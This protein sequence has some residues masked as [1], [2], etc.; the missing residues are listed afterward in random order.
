M[1][2]LSLKFF[3]GTAMPI[4]V[5]LYASYLYFVP[6][7]LDPVIWESPCKLFPLEENTIL[8]HGIKLHENAI[9]A[10]ESFAFDEHTGL[11]YSGLADGRVMQFSQMGE[12]MGTVLF[13]GGYISAY[14]K[15]TQ[16]SEIDLSSYTGMEESELF[17]SCQALL[18]AGKLSSD[19]SA[20][21]KCGRPLGL[22]IV[23][24]HEKTFLYTV[25]A[26]HGIF[27]IELGHDSTTPHRVTYLVT[28]NHL[29][30][31]PASADPAAGL[32][33]HFYNDI[34]V[35]ADDTLLFTDSSYK[36]SRAK[37]R[38]EVVDGAPRGRLLQYSPHTNQV[39]TLLCGLHF[40]NGIQFL[41]AKHGTSSSGIWHHHHKDEL[42]VVELARFR[43]LKV[44]ITQLAIEES[45]HSFLTSCSG[46][47]NRVTQYL[48]SPPKQP[49]TDPVSPAL[50]VFVDSLQGVPD[51]IRLNR[52]RVRTKRSQGEIV[53]YVLI[54]SASKSARPFS[55]LWFLYQST[56]ARQVI[57]KIFPVK[58][59]DLF[60]PKYGMVIAVDLEGKVLGTFQS[61]KGKIAWI[62]EAQRHPMTG[63][64]WI[65]SHASPYLAIVPSKHI[66]KFSR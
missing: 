34:E 66:P 40:P 37:N 65:G 52:Y 55:F 10:P 2:I 50:S 25:D 53:Q 21:K 29:T 14:N 58:L 42:L 9:H 26:H 33:I 20:E 4:I 6:S 3:F 13:V 60:I 43:V 39:R 23:Y 1:S 49:T 28:P 30:H 12:V 35:M 17:K 61:P 27:R 31:V 56:I 7:G 57:A 24:R 18:K 64:L 32:P 45:A 22:R 46:P 48:L 5:A 11:A 62:S 59:W 41:P 63:D 36:H 47:S 15:H 19:E 44:N 8:D 38:F 16:N 54:G 51:N